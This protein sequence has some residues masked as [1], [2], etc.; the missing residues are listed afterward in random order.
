MEF[1]ESCGLGNILL[2]WEQA[3]AEQTNEL[4]LANVCE[5]PPLPTDATLTMASF[6]RSPSDR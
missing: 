1:W 3:G 4:V 5:N 2:G 6:D